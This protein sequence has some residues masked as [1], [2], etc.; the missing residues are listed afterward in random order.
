MN[1]QLTQE[2]KNSEKLKFHQTVQY[3]MNN[4]IVKIEVMGHERTHYQHFQQHRGANDTPYMAAQSTDMTEQIANFNEYMTVAHIWKNAKQSG[5]K[6]VTVN[7]QT[8]ATDDIL[9]YM[10]NLK[11]EVLKNGFDENDPDCRERIAK[12]ASDYWNSE[13]ADLYAVNARKNAKEALGMTDNPVNKTPYTL[14][15]AIVNAQE[16]EQRKKLMV[17]NLQTGD[18]VTYSAPEC[19]KYFVPSKERTQEIIK[20]LPNV[21]NEDL[22]KIGAYLDKKGLKT[23]DEK[24]MFIT[25]QM[26]YITK[27]D[28]KADK[29]FANLLVS[30]CPPDK[31]EIL[32]ADGISVKYDKDV[33]TVTKDEVN[34]TA[35][36]TTLADN[37]QLHQQIK[38]QKGDYPPA[39]ANKK[40]AEK[41]TLADTQMLNA[42]AVKNYKKAKAAKE[43]AKLNKQTEKT[44]TQTSNSAALLKAQQQNTL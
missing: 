10:P 31:Q 17:E 6:T 22:L 36:I 15:G 5:A 28:P 30:V 2:L 38:A 19:L 23:D 25:E 8:I 29:D 34:F 37:T 43:A 9:N 32:Y 3:M 24:E 11:Q 44:T 35:P 1:E 21:S 7:D 39:A 14:A 13:R 41:R 18:G 33:A 26:I 27:R 12:V 40:V 20:D 4:T 16:W 42:I